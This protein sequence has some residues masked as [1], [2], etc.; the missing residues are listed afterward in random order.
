MPKAPRLTARSSSLGAILFERTMDGEV[1]GKPVL[2]WV[3]FRSEKL[4]A[5]FATT[6]FGRR[7]RVIESQVRSQQRR[8][9]DDRVKVGPYMWRDWRRWP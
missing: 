2:R 1:K 7:T 5:T 6:H 9:G 4:A 3:V 8:C